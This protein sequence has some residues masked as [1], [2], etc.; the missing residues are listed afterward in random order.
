MW[1]GMVSG[2]LRDPNSALEQAQAL[3]DL[4]A[5]QPVYQCMA[6][7][8]MGRAL[9][10]QGRWREGVDYSRLAVPLHKESG[11]LSHMRWAKLDEAEYFASQQQTERGLVLVAEVLIDS[12]EH[13]VVR[14]PALRQRAE[15][16]AQSNAGASAVAAAYRDA[17]Q[18]A[19]DQDARYF[20]L[21]AA[22]PF[23]RW[24]KDQGRVAEARA[25]LAESYGWFTEGFDT[26]ALKQAKALL[27][28]LNEKPG[29]AAR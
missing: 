27:D 1:A 16:L 14:S 17:L 23:A 26:L 28:E 8:N 25:V 24:L 2:F 9:M 15:L 4:A 18:C 11:L 19:R 5:T 13:A 7:Q 3:S 21:Q 10:L 20:E 22:T 29:K 12:D 6:D